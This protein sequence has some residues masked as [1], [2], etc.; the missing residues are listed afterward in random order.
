MSVN[1]KRIRQQKSIRHWQRNAFLKTPKKSP[2]HSPACQWCTT[3]TPT[4]C[5]DFPAYQ[6]YKCLN[7][8]GNGSIRL[9]KK[10]WFG[11]LR[12]RPLNHFG[13]LSTPNK[14]ISPR[15][16]AEWEKNTEQR[17]RLWGKSY[18]PEYNTR[19]PTFRNFPAP[20]LIISTGREYFVLFRYANTR[21][22]NPI[23]P[24]KLSHQ[25]ENIMGGYT[26]KKPWTRSCKRHWIQRQRRSSRVFYPW[27]FYR[28]NTRVPRFGERS[29]RIIML[30]ASSQQT[31]GPLT[32]A[33][34]LSCIYVLQGS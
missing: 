29:G 16:R 1:K 13:I 3:Q 22:Q 9:A 17:Y 8:R 24:F 19:R 25:K 4:R 5:G 33:V 31:G 23:T 18:S 14:N 32:D 21:E 20:V 10:W 12:L 7:H 28:Q 6:S 11:G 15:Q 27:R 34:F 26:N 30:L 2:A